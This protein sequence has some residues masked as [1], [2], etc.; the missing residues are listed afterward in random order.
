M[1]FSIEKPKTWKGL[2]YVL[3]SSLLKEAIA[4]NELD[5]NVHLKYWT[6]G[7]DSQTGWSILDGHYWLPNRH[8]DYAR[9]YIRAGVV[10]SA[11][12]KEVEVK[13]GSEALPEL[14]A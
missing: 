4:E 3:K 5:C 6:P 7:G 12:R 8:V 1:T 13:L 10:P 14:I 9:F 11:I 2:S